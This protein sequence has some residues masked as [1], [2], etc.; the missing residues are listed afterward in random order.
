[1]SQG[2]W[3]IAERSTTGALLDTTL[4]AMAS[5]RHLAQTRH[6]TITAVMLSSP[7]EETSIA[8][9][10]LSHHGADQVIS[11]THDLLAGY[12]VELWTHALGALLTEHTPNVVLMGATSIAKDMLPRLAVRL[13]TG[14]MP[15]ALDLTMDTDG[16]VEVTRPV[17]G[18]N[19][20]AAVR[21]ASFRPQLISLRPKAFAK[22]VP[23]TARP[24]NVEI[25]TPALSAEMIHIRT[26]ST[27]AIT[28][29][30]GKKLDEA[31]IVVS[32][33]RGLKGPENFHL[34]EGLAQAL[35][36]AIGASRAVVD[37]GW[38]PHAEQVGQ[39]GKT[40]T[41]QLYVAL[42]ISGAIQHQVGMSGSRMIIA[43]NKDPDAPIFEL[44]DVGIVG[45][46][47]E[48]VPLLTKAVQ[49]R[50]MA[51]SV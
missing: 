49:A 41:P 11:L 25:V 16:T 47:F 36:G 31:D 4:E 18:E 2:V 22:G 12:Q 20:R 32:G 48:I 23:D 26:L 37:A 29:G 13:G 8:E 5:A 28:P 9:T 10:T 21:M 14:I 50:Q 19:M 33:G 7:V 40:V 42:G 38:R 30:T 15:D 24:M 39:T 43:V 27:T 34:V 6:E 45:D 35:G 1:M 51:A 44:A 17:L 46:V 3:V